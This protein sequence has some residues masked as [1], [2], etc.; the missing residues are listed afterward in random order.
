MLTFVPPLGL[1]LAD[2]LQIRDLAGAQNPRHTPG[3]P[4]RENPGQKVV[5]GALLNT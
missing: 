1:G 4:S 5:P 2:D 3:D